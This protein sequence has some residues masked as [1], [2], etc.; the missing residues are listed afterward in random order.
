MKKSLEVFAAIAVALLFVVLPLEASDPLQESVS[1]GSSI[2][3]CSSGT[4]LEC[5]RITTTTCLQY[6]WVKLDGTVSPMGGGGAG[7][8]R[9]CQLKQEKV[10]TKYWS[11]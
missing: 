9:E 1:D 5:E 11:R 10:Q 4:P 6:V 8:T 2:P 3:E 7:Y